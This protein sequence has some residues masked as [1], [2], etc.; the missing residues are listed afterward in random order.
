MRKLTILLLLVL[1]L[2]ITACGGQ[3]TAE[4]EPTD[5]EED[6]FGDE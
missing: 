2:V 5:D 6:V 3:D 1:A 4:P